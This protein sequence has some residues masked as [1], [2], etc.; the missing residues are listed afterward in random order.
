MAEAIP[1]ITRI[2]NSWP[3]KRLGV[4][5]ALAHEAVFRSA[6]E[7]LAVFTDG[8]GLASVLLAFLDETRFGSAGK[9]LAVLAYCLGFARLGQRRAN[10]KRGDQGS[11]ENSLHLFPPTKNSDV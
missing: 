4:L 5:F 11:K 6:G 9:R 1:T 7:R 3:L 2:F 10:G 8:L